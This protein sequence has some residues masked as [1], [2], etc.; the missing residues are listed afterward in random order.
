MYKYLLV[1]LSFLYTVTA[2]AQTADSLLKPS[3]VKTLS[4]RQ[5]NALLNGEDQHNMGLVADINGYPLPAKAL[6]YKKEIDLSSV[7]TAAISKLNTALI[8]KK[9]EM[10]TFIIRNE[11]AMDS[12][13]RLK[14]LNDGIIIYYTNRYGLYQGELRNAILQAAFATWKQLS[15]PQIKKLQAFKND[16]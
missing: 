3:P 11:R 7:Q 5:Y 10:G 15:Q 2:Y 6:K 8:F 12:L 13:F 14:K 9:K 1:T 16:N 4:A